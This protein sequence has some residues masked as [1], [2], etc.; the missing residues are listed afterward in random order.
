MATNYHY[1]VMMLCCNNN[2]KRCKNMFIQSKKVDFKAQETTE[3]ITLRP[4]VVPSLLSGAT[5]NSL[6][7]INSVDPC[8]LKPNCRE[9]A[10]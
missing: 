7:V 10:S 8:E 1:I 3:I 4:L 6:Q 5:A 2:C 9:E